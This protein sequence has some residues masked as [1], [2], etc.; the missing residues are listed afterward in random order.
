[1]AGASAVVSTSY[2]VRCDSRHRAPLHSNISK[3]LAIFEKEREESVKREKEEE[4]RPCLATDISRMESL[5]SKASSA[6]KSEW[7][8]ERLKRL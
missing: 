8:L 7:S 1:V 5:A 6:V 4:A 2:G 3:C